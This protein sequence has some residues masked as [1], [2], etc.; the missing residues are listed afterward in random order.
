MRATTPKLVAAI[1]SPLNCVG[2]LNG[3]ETVNRT[4]P[5]APSELAHRKAPVCRSSAM[6]HAALSRR[7]LLLRACTITTSSK[8]TGS[9]CGKSS[10]NST[11]PKRS[12]CTS[13]R[14]EPFLHEIAVILP[15]APERWSDKAC[16]GSV[17]TV[18]PAQTA[19]AKSLGARLARSVGEPT[20]RCQ[21]ATPER[22]SSNRTVAP[23]AINTPSPVKFAL[24]TSADPSTF[25]FACACVIALE[26]ISVNERLS[27]DSGSH[28]L[29]SGL[30]GAIFC[31]V[32]VAAPTTRAGM[33]GGAISR[34]A[35]S[36][37]FFCAGSSD[38]WRSAF[39][40]Q[41]EAAVTRP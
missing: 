35:W 40:I 3:R 8:I 28:S 16:P 36:R 32:A 37:S 18:S 22:R 39:S 1:T 24:A 26:S 29:Q 11:W 7:E 5:A 10:E 2:E 17:T 6:S 20:A 9:P 19:T 30:H 25:A 27:H 4:P 33:L 31:C 12:K 14:I 15:C 13:H 23:S 21:R 34:I 38:G 41:C